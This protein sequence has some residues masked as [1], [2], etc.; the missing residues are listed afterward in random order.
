[1]RNADPK[2]CPRCSG[3]AGL[4]ATSPCA[5]AWE[6]YGCDVCFFSWRSSEDFDLPSYRLPTNFRVDASAVAEL[7]AFPAI[8]ELLKH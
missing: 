1:M 4:L 3:A 2:H 6:M 7:S 5:G 8:P